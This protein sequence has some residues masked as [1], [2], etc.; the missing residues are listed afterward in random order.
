MKI[1]IVT[2][3]N[4][5]NSGSFLQAYALEQILIA[6]GHEVRFLYRN[7]RGT[8]HRLFGKSR[9]VEIV[10]SILKMDFKSMIIPIQRWALYTKMHR[11]FKVCKIGSDY[12]NDTSL[13][14]LGSDTIWNF[15][16]DYF[17]KQAKIYTG[18][19]AQKGNVISYAASAA[20]TN[21]DLFGQVLNKNGGLNNL[22]SIMVR[23]QHTAPLK[24]LQLLFSLILQG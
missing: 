23:D 24:I 8:S 15:E 19:F 3:Y 6:Q 4:S 9:I 13:F 12:Y 20:N 17:V 21:E 18:A 2:V 11:H 10:K 1:T 14:I 5:E 22:S 7:T 16:D